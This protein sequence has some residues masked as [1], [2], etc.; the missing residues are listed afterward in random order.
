VPPIRRAT[1]EDLQAIVA[2]LAEFWGERDTT[3]LHHALFVHEFGDTALVLHDDRGHPIAYLLGFVTPTGVGYIHVVGVHE[4]HRKGG[5]A[6]ALY[7]EF[8]SLARARG[9]SALKAITRP[10]NHASLAFHR[11]L[12]FTATEHAGY[13]ALGEPRTVFWR[14]LG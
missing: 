1:I 9:A 13:T 4:N 11:A 5:L 12:G 8:E 3:P 6:R 14:D 2:S 10:G 7:D